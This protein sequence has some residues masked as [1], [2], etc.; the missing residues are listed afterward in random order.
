MPIHLASIAKWHQKSHFRIL[1]WIYLLWLLS[2]NISNLAS[3]HIR[4]RAQK[5]L[6]LYDTWY[7]RLLFN[8]QVWKLAEFQSK[9]LRQPC[10]WNKMS[11]DEG[12]TRGL[13]TAS[14]LPKAAV[15]EV[16]CSLP[17]V[18]KKIWICVVCSNSFS[19]LQPRCRNST[20][21]APFQHKR[22]SCQPWKWKQPWA[23]MAKTATMGQQSLSGASTQSANIPQS[24][25][26]Q[27][28]LWHPSQEVCSSSS[29][30]GSRYPASAARQQPGSSSGWR[31]ARCRF[32]SHG[33]QWGLRAP[34]P[35]ATPLRPLPLWGNGWGGGARRERKAI[36]VL[37]TS[38]NQKAEPLP[39]Q[40]AVRH[41][42]VPQ[43]L[44]DARAVLQ[45][46][47]L[48]VGTIT[49]L[50]SYT[51]STLLPTQTT[52]GVLFLLHTSTL[53]LFK[54]SLKLKITPA[55]KWSVRSLET[56]IAAFF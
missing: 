2:A 47:I 38:A 3:R 40:G 56:V 52:A 1:A 27:K 39:P 51:C 48:F 42:W 5:S 25:P 55:P 33:P 10:S 6:F 18:S 41:H 26:L 12:N 46:L 22:W 29:V 20:I 17:V 54:I 37:E 50:L 36:W 14:V 7:N 44:W 53:C 28:C 8:V 45:D 19:M 31:A 35:G 30:S 34:R 11:G 21:S 49:T 32:L 13:Q 15:L 23:Q 24:R 16:L 9:D 4:L 43:H